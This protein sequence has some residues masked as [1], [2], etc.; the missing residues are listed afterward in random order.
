ML[1]VRPII[2]GMAGI[3][4]AIPKH[5]RALHLNL[6]TQSGTHLPMLKLG[7]DIGVLLLT[8]GRDIAYQHVVVNVVISAR[9]GI[10]GIHGIVFVLQV[11]LRAHIV[12]ILQL[13][14]R[15]KA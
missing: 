13:S 9:R 1:G 10:L 4:L 3:V 11:R 6:V 12:G 5:I 8:L 7:M 2:L 15:V 14:L